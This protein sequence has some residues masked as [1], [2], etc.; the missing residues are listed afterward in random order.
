MPN[1]SSHFSSSDGDVSYVRNLWNKETNEE[2]PLLW[3][4]IFLV[5]YFLNQKCLLEAERIKLHGIWMLFVL[6]FRNIL[7]EC[8]AVLSDKGLT[9]ETSSFESLY[10][11]QLTSPQLIKPNYLIIL[12]TDAVP[13]VLKKLSPFNQNIYW[14]RHM[15]V[16]SMFIKMYNKRVNFIM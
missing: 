12:F 7:F 1:E 13:Q 15:I 2:R 10:G 16:S 5:L 14:V 3:K 8:H 9:L 6:L 11:G 4:I